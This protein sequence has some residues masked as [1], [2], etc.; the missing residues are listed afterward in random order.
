[1]DTAKVFIELFINFIWF[2]LYADMLMFAG[3]LWT[4]VIWKI[5][6]LWNVT[7]F[8]CVSCDNLHGDS[9]VFGPKYITH[10]PP[11]FFHL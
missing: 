3:V 2:I 9:P 8:W 11:I 1:M 5:D 6:L 10:L 7:V 4:D